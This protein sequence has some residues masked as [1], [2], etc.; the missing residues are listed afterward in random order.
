MKF[1]SILTNI[2]V[3]LV[4]VCSANMASAQKKLLKSQRDMNPQLINAAFT[5]D[6]SKTEGIVSFDFINE[7]VAFELVDTKA[8]VEIGVCFINAIPNIS[9]LNTDESKFVLEYHK[10]YQCITAALISDLNADEKISFEIP[11]EVD[12]ANMRGGR[13]LVAY[14]VNL[15]PAPTMVAANITTDDSVHGVIMLDSYNSETTDEF[16]L[17]VYPNPTTEILMFDFVNNNEVATAEVFDV[18][19]QLQ[20]KNVVSGKGLDV[21][22]L[23]EGNYLVTVKRGNQIVGS[24][25]FVKI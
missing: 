9:F 21:S 2:L 25:K 24:A 23:S 13:K 22:H 1:K 8:P 12:Y 6:D 10:E 7:G 16:S 3:V 19:G 4:L 17:E 5:L 15:T 20:Y 18:K 11:F 14:N